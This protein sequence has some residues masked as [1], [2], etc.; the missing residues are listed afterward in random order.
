VVAIPRLVRIL[1]QVGGL[2][3]KDV[4]ALRKLD[5][6]GF[7]LFV[8][9]GIHDIG[10]LLTTADGD[11]SLAHLTQDKF[12][13]LLVVFMVERGVKSKVV[14]LALPEVLLHFLQPIADR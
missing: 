9:S 14:R 7:V 6:L 11:E 8:V 4:G 12:P 13:L 3:V 2:T 10:E 5:D 1:I